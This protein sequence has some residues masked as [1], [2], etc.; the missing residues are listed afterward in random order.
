M[1]QKTIPFFS[2]IRVKHIFYFLIFS[3]ILWSCANEINTGEKE[4]F[5]KKIEGNLFNGNPTL[6]DIYSHESY[7]ESEQL[8]Q[9]LNS[10]NDS[11]KLA[12][13][14]ALASLKDSSIVI[15]LTLLLKDKNPKIREEVAYSLG[16]IGSPKAESFL[17][18]AYANE[19]NNKVKRQ[20]LESIGRCGTD[21]GLLFI[22][23]LNI[24][25]TQKELL[26]GQSWGLTRFAIR[27]LSSQQTTN[28]AIE[29]LSEESIANNIKVIVSNYFVYVKNQNLGK[30]STDFIKEFNNTEDE[31]LRVNIAEALGRTGSSESLNLLHSIL[32]SDYDYRIKVSA[33]KSCKNYSYKNSKEIIFALLQDDNL[34]VAIAAAEYFIDEGSSEDSD[35]Y[36]AIAK[37][38]NDWQ[39]RTIML[40]AALKYADDKEAIAGGIISGYNRAEN[41]YEKAFLLSALAGD[42]NSHRFVSEQTFSNSEKIIS[43]A[44]IRTLLEMRAN[45][46]FHE[47]YIEIKKE[48]GDNI[49]DEFALVFKKA[50]QSKDPALIYFGSL[51]FQNDQFQLGKKFSNTFFLNNAVSSCVLPRD[52]KTYLE[53]EKA[54]KFTNGKDISHATMRYEK[55]NWN[56]I[57]SISPNQK[58][59]IITTKG[60]IIIELDVND[61]P[62]AVSNFI[63]LI[64]ENYYNDTYFYRIAANTAIQ[65]GCK[66]GDGW[67]HGNFAI[68][69][70]ISHNLFTE[71]SVGMKNLGSESESLQWFITQSPQA[72]FDNKYTNFAQVVQ[73]IEV[74]HLIEV[75]DKIKSME[76]LN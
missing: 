54:I 66:R 19:K 1:K 18:A 43:T 14:S 29:I 63:K 50:I 39:S 61:A 25:S 51:A 41:I 23:S 16:V 52:I 47:S 62:I 22:A 37:Q 21:T 58:V 33:I 35:R 32:R 67:G 42:I 76:I 4:L 2:G 53:L 74:V 13:I 45:P 55:I 17:I 28:K 57:V 8:L 27:G 34:N 12:A 30:Y 73:G 49:Y 60:D 20:I 11:Y 26:I 71:G 69:S 44:G 70:E 15:P 38:L 72:K 65:N 46:E 31:F 5:E 56:T 9:F 59:K 7:N 75:G 68:Q 24:S 3:T 36:F 40:K 6:R 48:T 64:N 10:D